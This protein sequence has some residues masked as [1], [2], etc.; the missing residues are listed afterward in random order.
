MN[1]I[2]DKNHFQEFFTSLLAKLTEREQEV[3]KKRYQLTKDLT[4]SATLREIGEIYDITRERVRQIERDAVRRIA[5]LAKEQE[6]AEQLKNFEDACGTY[7]ERQGG[8]VREDYLLDDFVSKNYNFDNLHSNAFLF[9]LEHLFDSTEKID[10]HEHF[11]PV[12]V[13]RDIDVESIADLISK[14]TAVLQVEKKLKAKEEIIE[15]A[16][17]NLSDALK[18]KIAAL[19][20]KHDD[21][22]LEDFLHSYLAATSKIENNIMGQWGLA[23]WETVRPKKLGD[24]LRLIF[25][26]ESQPL[27]FSAMAQK[28]GE[29]EFDDKNICP[30]TVHNELI[31]NPEFVL[32]GRGVYALKDWGYAAGTVADIVE[33]VLREAGRPLS[34]D[35]VIAGVQK[36][37]SA[38]PSTIYLALINKDKFCKNEDGRYG[39]KGTN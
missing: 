4:E 15:L 3:L 26:K 37:R 25:Q 27:H 2:E 24:K 23:E 28:I 9:A 39:L 34:K 8:I 17:Q 10:N 29:A 21:L 11:Y 33:R 30:A 18:S 12:W 1:G 5:E 31:A 13:H 32:I 36:Q 7:L 22:T 14:M 6:Y 16:K 19:Q 35:E 38:N 20:A